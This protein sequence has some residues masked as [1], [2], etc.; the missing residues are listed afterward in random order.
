MGA[1]SDATR[2]TQ[3]WRGPTI[4]A[5][6]AG[7]KTRATSRLNRSEMQNGSPSA[8]NM[9]L[10]TGLEVMKII[11]RMIWK[12]IEKTVLGS[13][14]TGR[15]VAMEYHHRIYAAIR[16]GDGPLA[17]KMVHEHLSETIARYSRLVGGG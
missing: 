16:D 12:A 15:E 10:T 6:T 13:G 4:L 14:L 7:R 9:I 8:P 5:E 2:S 11:G 3:G 17:A 1:S